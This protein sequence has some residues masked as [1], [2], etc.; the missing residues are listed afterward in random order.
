MQR[1]ARP[2][3]ALAACAVRT[4]Q[5]DVPII[6][7]YCAASSRTLDSRLRAICDQPSRLFG[8]AANFRGC[9]IINLILIGRGTF[10]FGGR[11]SKVPTRPQGTTGTFVSATIMPSPCLKG[12]IE[13]VRVRPP[14]GKMMK[15]ALSSCNLRRNS[16]RACGPQF[17][18]HI[19][20]ALSMI[21]ENTLTAVV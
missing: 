3:N 4:S 17:F 19:G 14:S 8:V 5:R 16:A 13:P 10:R 20:K 6:W 7:R 18:R 9:P 15:I 21:A 12:I 11:A 2:T 1:T